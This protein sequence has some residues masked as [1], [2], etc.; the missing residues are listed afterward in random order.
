MAEC[1]IVASGAVQKRPDYDSYWIT[2]VA[3]T[4]L[5]Q[6]RIIL[7]FSTESQR[8]FSIRNDVWISRYGE[9]GCQLGAHS[10]YIKIFM[11]E[12]Y[13]PGPFEVLLIIKYQYLHISKNL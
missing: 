4:A 12:V 6:L 11:T 13:Y 8:L 1:S 5:G 2:G 3:H 10:E 7:V 9:Q